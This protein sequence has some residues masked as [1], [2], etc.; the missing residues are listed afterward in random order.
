MRKEKII[1]LIKLLAFLIILTAV[2]TGIAFLMTGFA[3][4]LA[5]TRERQAEGEKWLWEEITPVKSEIVVQAGVCLKPENDFNA[6]FN[7]QC[8]SVSDKEIMQGLNSAKIITRHNNVPPH[9]ELPVAIKQ[10]YSSMFSKPGK[11]FTFK[12]RAVID[13]VT[14]D[15]F[16]QLIKYRLMESSEIAKQLA[17][18]VLTGKNPEFILYDFNPYDQNR[19]PFQLGARVDY[20]VAQLKFFKDVE[21]GAV[22]PHE[23]AHKAAIEITYDGCPVD[24]FAFMRAFPC[25]QGEEFLSIWQ[26]EL[27]KVVALKSKLSNKNNFV[28]S[29][30]LLSFF[31]AAAAYEPTFAIFITE[32]DVAILEKMSLIKL[33]KL[34]N[35][36][37][38]SSYTNTKYVFIPFASTVDEITDNEI[39]DR[40][41]AASKHKVKIKNIQY[42]TQVPNIAALQISPIEMNVSIKARYLIQTFE[43]HKKYVAGIMSDGRCQEAFG[44]MLELN[45][46][47]LEILM[48]KSL[49]YLHDKFAEYQVKKADDNVVNR[50]VSI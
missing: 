32:E 43:A 3:R 49:A 1:R 12:G 16:K 46:T 47:I 2:L 37:D 10:T 33:G 50:M 27:D 28:L 13:G 5:R 22:V 35:L 40:L 24:G 42:Q 36:K 41:L 30:E 14:V 19:I 21:S 34:L 15:R 20:R 8:F 11:P 45:E 18:T 38:L 17:M 44:V 31:A 7:P 6:S 23:V 26:S 25:E 4:T 9:Y 29:A 39:F 48:P